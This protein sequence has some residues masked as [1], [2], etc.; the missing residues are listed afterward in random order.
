MQTMPN[1]H[2]WGCTA[3][4]VYRKDAKDNMGVMTPMEFN[5]RG[6]IADEKEQPGAVKFIP[7]LV[8][9]K[10]QRFR[11]AALA[12][13]KQQLDKDSDGILNWGHNK[14]LEKWTQKMVF[15]VCDH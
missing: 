7:L 15:K 14:A 12:E 3:A 9:S 4:D 8:G 6:D 5:T 1:R 10:L 2:F 13:F 11:D